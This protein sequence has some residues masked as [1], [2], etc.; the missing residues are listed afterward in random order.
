VASF[1][2]GL[3]Y[4]ALLPLPSFSDKL[5]PMKSV[6]WRMTKGFSDWPVADGEGLR[7]LEF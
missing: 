7:G 1:F 2:A 6:I 3:A 5:F 4:R